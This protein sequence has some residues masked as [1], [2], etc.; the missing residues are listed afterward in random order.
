MLLRTA[1]AIYAFL[2]RLWLYPLLYR[3]W[4]KPTYTWIN[5]R[6]IEYAY[7]LRWLSKLCPAT[8]L[9]VGTGRAA[10][11]SIM[12]NCGFRVTAIDKVRGYWSSPFLNHHFL[13]RNGD[14]TSPADG[15]TLDAVTCISVLEHIPDHEAAVKG[16]FSRLKPGGYLILTCPYQADRY[17]PNVYVEPQA[18]YGKD[19]PYVCQSF[20]QNELNGWLSGN[21]AE[22]VDAEFYRCFTG[23]LWTFGERVEPAEHVPDGSHGQLGCFILRKGS[24]E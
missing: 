3:K 11:P 18:S 13:V 19:R 2:T 24:Q 1:F 23:E 21:Q 7:S 5:E 4:A 10:W 16:M 15:E 9:D 12:S 22:V 14:I 20:S 8:I 6:P 17:S